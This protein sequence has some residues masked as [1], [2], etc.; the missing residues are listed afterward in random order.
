MRARW[1]KFLVAPGVFVAVLFVGAPAQLNAVA[2][3]RPH[4]TAGTNWDN[5]TNWNHAKHLSSGTHWDDGTNW[6]T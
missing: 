6:D 2:G 1:H 4:V 5:G 3:V